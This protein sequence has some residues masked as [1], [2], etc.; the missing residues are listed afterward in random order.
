MVE[1]I[2][3]DNVFV[4][5][6]TYHMNIEKKGF[7]EAIVEA[8]R[9]LRYIHLSESDRG[10]PGTGTVDWDS[11]CRGLARIGYAGDMV[12]ESFLT[13]HPDIARALAVWRPVA[14]G[15]EELERHGLPFLR[16]MAAAHGLLA[17]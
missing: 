9:H 1:R 14:A 8:G 12:V 5:L 7:D 2:G 17:S 11:V 4:H 6:D 3:E 13:L 10:V 16:R 15:P